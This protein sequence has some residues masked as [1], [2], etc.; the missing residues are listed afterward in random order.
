MVDHTTKTNI[1]NNE[2]SEK[3]DPSLS[4]IDEKEHLKYSL[5]VNEK[6]E[7][8]LYMKEE[9]NESYNQDSLL[10]KHDIKIGFCDKNSQNNNFY[11]DENISGN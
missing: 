2:Y 8:K 5:S 3:I 11:Y 7:G 9:N 10:D 1:P 6:E 4:K